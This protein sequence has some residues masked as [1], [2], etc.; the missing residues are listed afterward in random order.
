MD[1]KHRCN[2][3]SCRRV[4]A[5]VPSTPVEP[6]IKKKMSVHWYFNV[7]E[8]F[9]ELEMAASLKPS[10]P[11]ELAVRWSNDA[12]KKTCGRKEING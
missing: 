2:I 10:A 4:W 8:W 5:K 12:S 6:T 9:F 3:R 1:N 11:V 7:A